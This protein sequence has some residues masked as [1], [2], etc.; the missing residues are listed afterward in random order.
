MLDDHDFAIYWLRQ[1]KFALKLR[2]D[3]RTHEFDSKLNAF[4]PSQTGS[5]PSTSRLL[6]SAIIENALKPTR[7]NIVT[8]PFTGLPTLT[9]VHAH[10]ITVSVKLT[11]RYGMADGLIFLNLSFLLTHSGNNTNQHSNPSDCFVG[12][13]AMLGAQHNIGCGQRQ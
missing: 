10:G 7:L 2:P 12:V 4:V 9:D 6:T 1:V 5:A 13:C 3:P 11:E 8:D